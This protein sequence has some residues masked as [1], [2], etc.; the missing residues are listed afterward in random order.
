MPKV[1]V[2]NRSGH[3]Y[4]GAKRFGDLVY[5][6]EGRTESPFAVTTIYAS[7]AAQLVDSEPD[8][9]LL[10]TGLNVMNVV[11]SGIFGFLHGKLN[12]LIYAGK[13]RYAERTVKLDELIQRREEKSL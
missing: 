8:D 1:Y 10:L 6:S 12:L 3:D 13:N 5:L 7:F 9:Y 2:V 4:A 11:A